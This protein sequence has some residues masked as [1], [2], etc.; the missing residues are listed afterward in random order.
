VVEDILFANFFDFGE[1]KTIVIQD[2]KNSRYIKD[3]IE[4]LLE[5]PPPSS[6]NIIP[7]FKE[8]KIVET[9]FNIAASGDI[10]INAKGAWIGRRTEDA[11]DD[12]AL[13]YIKHRAADQISVMKEYQLALPGAT[14]G[15]P[16]G[17]VAQQNDTP[18][19][20]QI[21]TTANTNL[22]SGTNPVSSPG[23]QISSGTATQPF[24]PLAGGGI[25]TPPVRA[26]IP[27]NKSAAPS[28]G[29]NLIGQLELWDLS[30]ERTIDKTTLEFDGLNVSQIK[31]ILQR[32][33]LAYQAGFSI[34]YEDDVKSSDD[35]GGQG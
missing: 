18:L 35:T 8:D 5:P 24:S 15:T 21:N 23:G 19:F 11:D 1:F 16:I 17:T 13:N 14:G 10:V 30:L 34:S 2:A 28:S 32:I 9:I 12:S 29:I 22:A 4:N 20:P 31:Q 27:R 7:Y 33:P 6:N 3:I 25:H 26:K